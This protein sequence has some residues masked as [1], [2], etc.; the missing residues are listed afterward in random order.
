MVG[1]SF[2]EI[3]FGNS[4]ALGMPCV[5]VGADDARLLMATAEADPAARFSLDLDAMSIAGP[6]VSVRVAL[7]SAARESFVEG[8]WDATGLL[9]DRYHDLEAVAERLPYLNGWRAP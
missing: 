4:V 3:F 5:S 7:P 9:L 6:G 2:S 8:T 1:V